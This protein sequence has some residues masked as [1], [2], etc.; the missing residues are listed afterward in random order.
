MTRENPIQ[1]ALLLTASAAAFAAMGAVIK[2]I[3][4]ELPNGMIVFFRNAMG[5][6]ALSPWLLRS[7]FS[8]IR[9]PCFGM[10]FTRALVGL[11]GMYCFFFAIGNLNLGEAMLLNYSA[12]LFIPFIAFFWLGEPLPRLAGWAVTL[13]FVGIALILKPGMKLFSPAALVGLGAG[14]LT[15]GAFVSIRRLAVRE[16][17]ARIVF[18]FGI[19]STMISAMPLV[20][21]WKMPAAELWLRLAVMGILATGGQLLM[22]RAYALAPAARIGT[23]SYATVVFSA[24]LGWGIWGEVLDYSSVVGAMLVCFAGVITVRSTI[25]T[26]E[27]VVRAAG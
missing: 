2:S 15:A 4:A 26:E 20:W 9:T 11:A 16:P 24:A 19:V 3:S 12:P 25:V 14:V 6:L 18:Y 10:H 22:T 23:F 17:T 7:G 8:G 13:G 21:I 1:G 27:A 5:L